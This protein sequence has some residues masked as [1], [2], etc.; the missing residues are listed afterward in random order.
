MASGEVHICDF[1]V[2]QDKSGCAD[3]VKDLELEKSSQAIQGGP[4][5]SQ[6]PSQ[7]NQ[8]EDVRMEAGIREQRRWHAAGFQGG[9]KGHKTRNADDL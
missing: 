1:V 6:G 3:V 7:Q 9:R 4:M 5:E 8:R 2:S